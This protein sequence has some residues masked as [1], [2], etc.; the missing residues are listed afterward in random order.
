L[1]GPPLAL[2]ALVAWPCG[3]R[4]AMAMR[5]AERMGVDVW[6]GWDGWV[7]GLMMSGWME[8]DA[9]MGCMDCMGW[10]TESTWQSQNESVEEIDPSTESK[11]RWLVKPTKQ[12]NTPP[13]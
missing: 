6:D 1:R 9:C 5:L 10:K 7:N 11:S 12:K 4:D 2:L 13:W 3:L 8:I